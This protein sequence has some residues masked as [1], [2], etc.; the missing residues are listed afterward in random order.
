MEEFGR[1]TVQP[2]LRTGRT[3]RRF[4]VAGAYFSLSFKRMRRATQ[5]RCKAPSHVL[6][7][8]SSVM[9]HPRFEPVKGTPEQAHQNYHGGGLVDFIFHLIDRRGSQRS[10]APGADTQVSGEPAVEIHERLRTTANDRPDTRPPDRSDTLDG[11][12]SGP[13]AS[14]RFP[15]RQCAH[16]QAANSTSCR[17]SHC[18]RHRSGP[19]R[20]GTAGQENNACAARAARALT[21]PA[22]REL[23]VRT[24]RPQS[25]ISIGEAPRQL[26]K[27]SRRAS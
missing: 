12:S 11:L 23:G 24:G 5:P 17:T 2:N 3:G 4:L 21:S 18:A 25:S 19:G 20:I 6:A 15:A 13:L 27:I 26:A 9:E 7:F 10:P 14:Q 22:H 8:G 1:N 16:G